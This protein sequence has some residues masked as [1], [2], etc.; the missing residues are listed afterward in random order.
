MIVR[1]KKM[2]YQKLLPIFLTTASILFSVAVNARTNQ[3][4]IS[5]KSPQSLPTANIVNNGTELKIQSG[6]ITQTIKASSLNVKVI[7]GVN[8]ETLRTLPVQN[9]S[10]KRFVPQAVSFDPKTGNLA[11]GVLLQECVETQQSAVF[12]LEPQA[13]WR[14]YAVYRVQLPGEKTLPDKFS[15]YSFRSIS[16]VGFRNNDLRIKHGDVSEAEALV[17]F[18]PSQ[19]PAGKYASC[20]VTSVVEGGNLCPNVKPE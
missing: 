6:Q 11:V 2:K 20:V 12:V 8:C 1:K 3:T 15:T 17:V 13:N 16:Q 14:N 10:G 19:T 9:V 5:Q 4:T 7:D 18:K